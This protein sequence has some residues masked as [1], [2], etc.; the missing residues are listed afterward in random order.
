MLPDQ[1]QI[2]LKEWAVTVESLAQGQQI[3]LLR[4]GG[5]HEEGKDFKVIHP[6]FL[7]YPTYEHQREDLLK[8]QHQPALKRLLTE[9]PRGETI[10]FTHWAASEEIIEVSDQEKVDDLSS[11]HIWTDEYAQS[12]LRWKPMLPLSIMLLRIYRLEQ[13]VTVPYI[14]EYGGC[15]SW[16]EIIPKVNLGNLKPVLSDQEF[17][18]Q[19][20][21]IKGSLGLAKT[22]S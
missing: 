1:C 18:R 16:V 14:P 17:G 3:L 4:K 10:A 6:E 5:I 19:V 2:A 20:D 7:L 13:P 9:S 21:E 8:P 11:H 12:R 22:A 15:T